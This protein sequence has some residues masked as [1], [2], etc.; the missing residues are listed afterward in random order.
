MSEKRHFSIYSKRHVIGDSNKYSILFHALEQAE[1][2]DEQELKKT[3]AAAGYKADFIKA[4]QHYLY[5]LLLRSLSEFHSGKSA[6][7]RVKQLLT[8]IEILYDKALFL[9]C[10]KEIQKAIAICTQYELFDLLQNL[11]YWER[12]I[13]LQNLPGSRKEKQ[14]LQSMEELNKVS[15]NLIAYTQ[16]YT[17]AVAHRSRIIAVRNP[18]A[19]RAFGKWLKQKKLTNE[20]EA[21]S[22][23]A[24]IRFHQVHAMWHNVSADRKNELICN[25]KIIALMDSSV[26]IRE[27]YPIDYVNV[28][29]RIL[30]IVKEYKPELF[31]KELAHFRSIKPHPNSISGMQ[32]KAQIFNFS[33]MMQLSML[34]GKSDFEKA[35]ILTAEL[36]S[37]LENYAQLIPLSSRLTLL[38]ELAYV[39]YATGDVRQSKKKLNLI[40]TGFDPALRPEIY[41]FARL[42]NLLVH[43]DLKNY[44]LISSEAGSVSYYFRKKSLEYKTENLILKFFRNPDIFRKAGKND[45][46]QLREKLDKIKLTGME[47]LAMKYFDFSLWAE[48]KIQRKTM[49]QIR[50]INS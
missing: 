14:I 15:A 6:N 17:E 36:E 12:K 32:M 26:R 29:S 49:M 22:V 48:S 39:Y 2:Y 47:K 13:S 21:L 10:L 19:F 16:L 28:Y 25:R 3:V 44:S 9:Q 31:E 42:L 23:N 45:F 5:R 35:A 4:D 1:N 18:Q 11:Y 38:Y 50:K 41:N 20:N 27:E 40:F 24:K 37:G 8:E 33:Y 34:I 43:Y 7:L 46:I 30:S